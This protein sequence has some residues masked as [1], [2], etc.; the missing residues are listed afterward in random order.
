[1]VTANSISLSR[2]R[3]GRQSRTCGASAVPAGGLSTRSRAASGLPPDRPLRPVCEKLRCTET[4]KL[5]VTPDGG[6]IPG[7]AELKLG[8]AV[9]SPKPEPRWNADRCAPAAAGAAV[10]E[11]TAD[12]RCVCR[13]SL[14]IFLSFFP[15]R[16]V[17]HPCRSGACECFHRH[18]PVATQHG[19]PNQIGGDGSKQW[20]GTTRALRCV[21]RTGF[22]SPPAHAR[23][24]WWGGVRGGGTL[25]VHPPAHFTDVK[26]RRPSPPLRGGGEK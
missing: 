25:L 13:R 18:W 19:A 5:R 9:R 11:A 1:M 22:Y 17:R 23:S 21:A 26:F 10:A 24:A 4:G 2:T 14:P 8:S 7:S 12:Y 6:L 3:S 15:V 16:S 20:R